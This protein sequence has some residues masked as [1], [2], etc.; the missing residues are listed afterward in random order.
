MTDH[1]RSFPSHTDV[2]AVKQEK[3]AW[4]AAK[5]ILVAGGLRDAGPSLW[6]RFAA[7]DPG[8]ARLPRKTRRALQRRMRRSL[9]GL[10]LSCTLGQIPAALAVRIDVGVGG[11]T[12]ADAITAANEDASSGDCPAGSGADTLTLPAASTQTL[13]SIDNGTFGR[14]GL[15]VV[16]STIVIEGNGSTIAR[17]PAAPAF[18]ILA[19]GPAGDLTL[20]ETTVTRGRIPASTANRKGGGIANYGTL[21]LADSTIAGNTARPDGG[22][23]HNAGSLT[24]TRSTV[25]GNSTGDD[26]G[27][28][29]ND[30][31]ATLINSTVSGNSASDNGGGIRNSGTWSLI[32]STVS[33]N[34]A[35]R[36]GGGVF[37]KGTLVLARSIVS[38]NL[39]PRA[40]R[41]VR[42]RLIGAGTDDAVITDGSNLFGHDGSAGITGFAPGV[43]D[44][45][46]SIPLA[47]IL[48]P[49]LADNGAPTKT[50]ALLTGS[51][52]IDAIPAASCGTA[53]DQRGIGRPQDG[54][55]DSLADCD[56]GA[57]ELQLP[58]LPPPPAPSP[59]PPPP[60]VEAKPVAQAPQVRCMRSA[61]RVQITCDVLQGS[62][63]SCS[64]PVRVF[65]RAGAL[66]LDDALA[67]NNGSRRIRFASGVA[68]IAPGQTTNVRLRLTTRGR[69]IVRT[70]TR[71][72][73]R[74]TL[75]IQNAGGTFR[76]AVRVRLTLRR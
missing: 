33:G 7:Y 47:A 22:G 67:A 3:L 5:V 36:F 50:H 28:I 15:P 44:V 61:C 41:E 31:A 53:S 21:A 58:P 69:Q 30:G 13:T 27:G 59:P 60:L 18:R 43:S 52:A 73:L 32:D 35:Q 71:K 38:G 63:T 29:R 54:D 49:T 20:Q 26:G 62:G 37:N 46:P 14:T 2:V 1:G 9:A 66:R 24:V 65:V 10:A 19:I 45:V 12:L 57:F 39:S 55:G 76:A 11:C 72:T 4:A 25:S 17:D 51:P 42:N 56:I 68:N 6:P 40:G 48:D 34:S 64:S 23:L 75:E 74:G 16:R 70:S 8:L